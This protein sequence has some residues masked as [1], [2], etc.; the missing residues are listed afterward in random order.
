MVPGDTL[1]PKSF[2]YIFYTTNG[3]SGEIHLYQRFLNGTFTAFIPLYDSCFE[4]DSFQ[5]GN[6]RFHFSGSCCE[7]SGVTT[8]TIALTIAC[9]LVTTGAYQVPSWPPHDQEAH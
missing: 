4:L 8:G 1:P 7:V 6:A 9:A 2:C 3:N 5:L